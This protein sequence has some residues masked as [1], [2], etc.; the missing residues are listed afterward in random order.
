MA[1]CLYGFSKMFF[2]PCRTPLDTQC[3]FIYIWNPIQITEPVD[4]TFCP[5]DLKLQEWNFNNK[6][7]L[8]RTRIHLIQVAQVNPL[9]TESQPSHNYMLFLFRRVFLPFHGY[10]IVFGSGIRCFDQ[11]GLKRPFYFLVLYDTWHLFYISF[12]PVLRCGNCHSWPRGFRAMG[13]IKEDS[14]R[15]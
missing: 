3:L 6:L 7:L 5:V 11:D 2:P 9:Y 14:W 15:L 1:A 13:K 10:C 8:A 4:S 12:D